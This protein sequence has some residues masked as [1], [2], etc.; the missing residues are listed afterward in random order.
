MLENLIKLYCEVREFEKTNAK[1]RGLILKNS[2]TSRIK[3]L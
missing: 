2:L 1:I 3:E